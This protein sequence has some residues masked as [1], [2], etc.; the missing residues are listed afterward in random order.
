MSKRGVKRLNRNNNQDEREDDEW[1]MTG[2]DPTKLSKMMPKLNKSY[3]SPKEKW[4]GYLIIGGIGNFKVLDVR[5]SHDRSTSLGFGNGSDSFN[6][7]MYTTQFIIRYTEMIPEWTSS[8]KKKSRDG[9][10]FNLIE[11]E[12]RSADVDLFSFT[13]GDIVRANQYFNRYRKKD[14]AVKDKDFELEK[15]REKILVAHGS[16][17]E[18]GKD[19]IV[20]KKFSERM[21]ELQRN[22]MTRDGFSGSPRFLGYTS[23]GTI[24][25]LHKMDPLMK[26][27]IEEFLQTRIVIGDQSSMNTSLEDDYYDWSLRERVAQDDDVKRQKFAKWFKG[28]V[29]DNLIKKLVY[30]YYFG[31]NAYKSVN[32]EIKFDEPITMRE[33]I[34]L[35]DEREL[36]DGYKNW[37]EKLIFKECNPRERTILEKQGE[38]V[39]SSFDKLERDGEYLPP[40]CFRKLLFTKYSDSMVRG[41]QSAIDD[42][43]K[44]GVVP[45]RWRNKK[46]RAIRE[47]WKNERWSSSTYWI[48]TGKTKSLSKHQDK[49]KKNRDFEN[50]FKQEIKNKAENEDKGWRVVSLDGEDEPDVVYS[51]PARIPEGDLEGGLYR[52]WSDSEA[53]ARAIEIDEDRAMSL[54]EKI[55]HFNLIGYSRTGEDR[56]MYV[57][58]P[59]GYELKIGFQEIMEC[60]EFYVPSVDKRLPKI[61]IMRL[62]SNES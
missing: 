36:G 39:I 21:K 35:I 60:E 23:R 54:A 40:Y 34:D 10:N 17:P 9:R 26:S 56:D 2:F 15:R 19:D 29:S 57:L 30:Y 4:K 58:V 61:V 18:F 11:S 55:D 1:R 42:S 20:A 14:E 13:I 37:L 6:V 32:E 28:V 31:K 50:E 12:L 41:L 46:N 48:G 47:D 59:P 43:I 49:F 38:M 7:T 45:K 62:I 44:D 24:F 16:T 3:V 25:K 33:F 27:G 51:I 52:F 53:L 8:G 5:T 22:A